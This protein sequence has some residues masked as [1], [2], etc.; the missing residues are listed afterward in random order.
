[1][2]RLG[3]L[4]VLFLIGCNGG[5][6][7]PNI[8]VIQN[9]MDQESIKSQ[10]WV[11]SEGEKLQM[12]QPPEGT[13][14]RGFD[15]YPY[16]TDP[17]GS[18][19][20]VNSLA[21]DFSPEV[22]ELGQKNYAIYCAVCH[23]DQAKGDGPVATKMPLRPPSLLTDKVRNL[24]DGRIFHIITQGQGLMGSYASQMTEPR[25]RWAVVNYIRSLQKGN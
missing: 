23:G 19:K 2:K 1:M 11:P 12:L 4:S 14:P 16:A 25:K 21:G 8:E 6:N 15:V 17:E 10:D 9:M 18:A 13:V 5:K 7:Q 20:L 3:F 22:I 24:P